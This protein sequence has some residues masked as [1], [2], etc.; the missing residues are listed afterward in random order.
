MCQ[1]GWQLFD[2]KCYYF[3]SRM[4]AWGSSRAW[5]QTQGGD[6]L[7]VNNEDEQVR[8]GQADPEIS[9]FKCAS[10]NSLLSNQNFVLETSRA[11]DQRNTRLWIGLTDAEEEGNWLWV[12]GRSV[13]SGLQ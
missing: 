2:S 3:S 1:E 7:I 11:L 13:T 5:C 8:I 6:L 9:L 10:S 12:D 4:L